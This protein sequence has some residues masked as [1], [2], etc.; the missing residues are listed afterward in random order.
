[1]FGAYSHHYSHQNRGMIMNSTAAR[2]EFVDPKVES[3]AKKRRQKNIE[4]R[5]NGVF[6][7]RATVA[8]RRYFESLDTRDK[9]L[10]ASRA[11]LKMELIKSGKWT[12]LDKTRT[13]RSI[14]TIGELCDAYATLMRETGRVRDITAKTNIA[15]LL[16]I[17]GAV[18]QTESPR[19]LSASVLTA[20]LAKRYGAL[21]APDQKETK[22][23]EYSARRT[24]ASN[25]VHARSMVRRG[26]WEDYRQTG[27]VLP[28]LD[29]FLSQFV[30]K[31]PKV[32]Y[33]MPP[34]TL[35]EPTIEAG[36]NLSGIQGIVW[37]LAY[38]LGMRAGEIAAAKWSW[39]EREDTE[40]GVRWWMVV[41]ER[42]DFQPKGISGRIPI[43]DGVHENLL[44]LKGTE[45]SDYMLPYASE[46]VRTDCVKRDFSSW[47]RGKGWTSQKCAHE[48][49]KLRGCWWFAKYGV[50]RAYKW[51]R[52]ANIQTT[53]DHYADLPMMTEPHSI[54]Q[55]GRQWKP[56]LTR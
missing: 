20:D 24:I 9:S 23:A 44:K 50:E 43:F 33:E 25:L 2:I 45:E 22:S 18:E 53:L 17:I 39:I 11:K 38:D 31:I 37:T 19:M 28:N 56:L 21:L 32:R 46:T 27:L 30:T 1:M 35:Y 26:L 41:K 47:M 42:E 52:H 48:L 29:G 16:R 6:Y 3:H 14:C 55:P 5:E 13:K 54:E 10:A 40:N 51:L 34:R 4:R 49:R 8:G 36:R 7:F 12:D 15:T